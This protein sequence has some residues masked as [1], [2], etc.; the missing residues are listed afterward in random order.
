MNK[1]KVLHSKKKTAWNVVNQK[2]GEKMVSVPY[3]QLDKNV[4]ELDTLKSLHRA[5]FISSSIN[6][7]Q[8]L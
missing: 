8:L 3:H 4:I 5:Q 6:N 2:S 1:T 7:S